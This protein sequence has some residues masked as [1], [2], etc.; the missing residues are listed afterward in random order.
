MG[1]VDA[2]EDVELVA[3][4]PRPCIRDRHGVHPE[5]G[6]R[7]AHVLP[8][9]KEVS[10]GRL[11]RWV[12]TRTSS[13]SLGRLASSSRYGSVG[14]RTPVE[15]ST[16]GSWCRG[17]QEGRGRV[18]LCTSSQGWRRKKGRKEGSRTHGTSPTPP[19]DPEP[20][21][22]R[23]EIEHVPRV[24]VVWSRRRDDDV[25]PEARDRSIHAGLKGRNRARERGF[26]RGLGGLEGLSGLYEGREGREREDVQR[27]RVREGLSR[28]KS[29]RPPAGR[30]GEKGGQG[31]DGGDIARAL[32]AWPARGPGLHH[33][34]HC[35]A[36]IGREMKIDG[37]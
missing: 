23:P 9:G 17:E 11:L 1:P 14:W 18:S 36:E 27:V 22:V 37:V 35:S 25:G 26:G 19:D 20:A 29:F 3:D 30:E 28:S 31:A 15:G 16:L 6:A 34:P 7:D 10:E 24:L 12:V 32:L 21:L 2:R 33:E 8:R 5:C 4:D 13:S